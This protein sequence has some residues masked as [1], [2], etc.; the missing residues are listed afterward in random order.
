VF[1][2]GASG[3]VGSAAVQLAKRRGARVIAQA[4]AGKADALMALGASR[5]VERGSDLVQAI[6][7][8]SVDVVID[9]VG[10]DTWPQL[11][12]ILKRGG[13]YVVS[14]AIAGPMVELDLRTLYLKD[15]T[16]LGCTAQ[17]PDVF[18]NLIGYI[19]RGEIAPLIAKTY[20]LQDIVAAQQEFQLKR[21]VGK[22]VLIPPQE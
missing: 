6:G 13:K 20:V 16:F 7:R 17:H 4:G 10:G 19:E 22:I 9:I 2:T 8:E 14:G 18:P 1:I 11:L 21:H 3:G 12:D 15:L 5:V